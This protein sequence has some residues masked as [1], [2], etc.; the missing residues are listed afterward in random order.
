M[1]DETTHPTPPVQVTSL[2]PDLSDGLWHERPERG[3]FAK[4]TTS[5]TFKSSVADT[6]W[7]TLGRG[8]HVTVCGFLLDE[9]GRFPVLYRGPGVRSVK[10]CWS[11]P[12][13]LH[14]SGL[15]LP[16]QLAVEAMEELN[17]KVAPNATHRH[18]GCYENLMTGE[19]WHWVVHVLA[20]YPCDLS[21]L[22]NKEPDKHPDVGLAR[23]LDVPVDTTGLKGSECRLVRCGSDEPLVPWSPGL[24]EFLFDHPHLPVIL[25]AVRQHHDLW[26]NHPNGPRQFSSESEERGAR[27]SV[28]YM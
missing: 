7:N 21:G 11:L 3:S 27:R 9:Q 5:F 25:E 17:V 13:G 6:R 12:S 18:L 24:D 26:A 15:T 2:N 14:E 22:T 20:V 8:P 16:E 10:N 23:F 1:T 28:S 19:G 4:G